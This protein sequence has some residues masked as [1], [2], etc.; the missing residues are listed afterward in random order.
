VFLAVLDEFLLTSVQVWEK[1]SDL[2]LSNQQLIILINSLR[3]HACLKNVLINLGQWVM[4][5]S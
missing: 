5:N 3:H 4:N 2:K 1:K